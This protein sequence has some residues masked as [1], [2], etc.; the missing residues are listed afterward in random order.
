MKENASL[1]PDLTDAELDSETIEHCVRHLLRAKNA[2]EIAK[3]RRILYEEKVAA[4][5]PCPE[6]GS[7]TVTLTDGTKVTV[8]RGLLYAADFPAIEQAF[9]TAGN[10]SIPIKIKTTRELDEVGYHWIL[11]NDSA[12]SQ[13]LSGLVTTKPAK[14]S[15]SVKAKK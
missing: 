6:R 2:E 8:T 3:A 7:K 10:T 9:Q 12:S 13:L 11:E 15:I 4:H 14:T 5:V 1:P